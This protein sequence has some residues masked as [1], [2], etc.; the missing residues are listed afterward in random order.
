[1]YLCCYIGCI[2]VTALLDSG[3]SINIVSQDFYDFLPE[4]CKSNFQLSNEVICL[5]N[6]QSVSVIGTATVKFRPVS[7]NKSHD[8][9]VYIFKDTSHPFILG[10]DYM[11]QS[12]IVLDFGK[13]CNTAVKP[14]TK[15]VCER[16]VSIPPNSESIVYGKLHKAIQI[17]MQG[18]CLPH[19][20]MT[21][22][23]LL[24][25]KALITCFNHQ[26]VPVKILNPTAA[27]VH[28]NKG[29]FLAKFEL[30]DNSV[31]IHFLGTD[32]KS[33]SHVF[34]QSRNAS[35]SVSV[36]RNKGSIFLYHP[37]IN[38]PPRKK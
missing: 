4:S 36:N 22:K 20:D 21:N 10:I 18:Q 13:A 6:N 3:S 30:C 14:T 27:T 32:M 16:S 38:L 24:I 33:C 2:T 26:I 37:I 35:S 31:D 7:S 34:V 12:G 5:A 8:I 11:Q 29:S 17:G 23:G 1:M 9:F 25:S 28:I 15:I 19:S